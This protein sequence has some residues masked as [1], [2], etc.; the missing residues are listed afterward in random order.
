MTRTRYSISCKTCG[1]HFWVK[2]KK[3][4]SEA[5]YCS[6][7]CY[8]ENYHL[9]PDDED[10]FWD[11]VEVKS[12]QE[13][14]NWNGGLRCGYGV[15]QF[16]WRSEVASRASWMI[17][18]GS[19]PDGLWVLHKCDN[20]KCVNPSHLFLGTPADNMADKTAKSRNNAPFGEKHWATK[21]TASKVRKIRMLHSQGVKQ[22]VLAEMFKEHYGTISKI[23]LKQRWAHVV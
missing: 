15:L 6:H 20:P 5:K 13:C 21:L 2:N 23:I 14:W 1:N 16:R 3:R 10:R 22:C 17:H 11:R 7:K 4:A 9:N 8:V 19:I 18:H 12:N